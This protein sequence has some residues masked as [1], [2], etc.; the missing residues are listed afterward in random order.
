MMNASLPLAGTKAVCLASL[1]PGPYTAMLLADLGCDVIVIDRIPPMVTSVPENRDPRRR[2]QKSIALDLKNEAARDILYDLIRNAD[3]LTE[4]MRP[5][6]A[7]RLGLD[8]EHCLGLNPRLVYA[9]ITGWG[10]QGPLSQTAGH[11]INYIAL[12]GALLAMG[13]S[14]RPPPVPLNLLGDYAGGGLFVALGIVSALFEIQRTGRGK[15]IDGAIIDGV[16]SL[17][18]ATM[19]MLGT[20][21]W[22]DRA[23]NVLDGSAPYYRAYETRDGGFIAVGAIEPQFY[24]LMLDGLG[25]RHSTWPQHERA[26]WP[27]LIEELTRIFKGEDRETWEKRFAG[28]DACITPVLSFA[29]AT[30]H[31]HHMARNSYVEIDHISQPAPGPRIVGHSPSPITRPPQIGRDTDAILHSLGKTSADITDL[32]SRGVVE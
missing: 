10:Q 19:G 30:R 1:G 12:S 22:G 26:C 15:V 25:L 27:E 2:G 8:P 17:T 16:A 18:A 31:P 3:I 23:T 29:E 28:T 13:E 11:D 7:E 5:G 14:D 21:R 4:G 20:G 9:R 24:A 6:V 32:R